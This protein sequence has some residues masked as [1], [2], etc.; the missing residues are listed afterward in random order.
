M[1]AARIAVVDRLQPAGEMLRRRRHHAR[2]DL[3][4]TAL[5]RRCV[6]VLDDGRHPAVGVADDAAV[7][8]GIVELDRQQRQRAR[9]SVLDDCLKCLGARQRVGAEQHKR[10]AVFAELRQRLGERMAGSEWGILQRP[11][12][13]AVGKSPAHRVT[14][15]TVDDANAIGGELARGIDHVRQQRSSTQRMQNLGNSGAHPLA[16][17]GSENRD[18][19]RGGLGGRHGVENF[20][21]NAER[22]LPRAQAYQRRTRHAMHQ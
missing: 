7:T 15:V 6:L 1:L 11:M 5:L 10:H 2:V 20:T 16:H 4:N 22:T 19:E 17:P 9:A 18:V 3:A 8:G 14:A 12:E 21:R 13:V